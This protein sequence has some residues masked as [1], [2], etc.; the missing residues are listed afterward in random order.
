VSGPGGDSGRRGETSEWAGCGRES[1]GR[2]GAGSPASAESSFFWLSLSSCPK[3]FVPSGPLLRLRPRNR[4]RLSIFPNPPSPPPPT[5]SAAA[6]LQ[7]PALAQP[8]ERAGSGAN[9]RLQPP[10]PTLLSPRPAPGQQL[11]LTHDDYGRLSRLEIELSVEETYIFEARGDS[12]VAYQ[13][14]VAGRAL[15]Q[16]RWRSGHDFR[17]S[18]RQ[19]GEITASL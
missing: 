4:L 18:V 8:A 13:Q 17:R 5:R 1:C 7:R 10:A 15:A 2:A 3:P 12:L 16:V 14:P 11:T 19:A 9:P 6:T